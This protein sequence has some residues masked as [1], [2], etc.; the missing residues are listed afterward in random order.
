VM[1][2]TNETTQPTPE[3]PAT[4]PRAVIPPASSPTSPSEA[5]LLPGTVVLPSDPARLA[6]TTRTAVQQFHAAAAP[7]PPPAPSPAT[8]AVTPRLSSQG[9][10]HAALVAETRA[11]VTQFHASTTSPAPTGEAEK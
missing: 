8:P 11:I 10:D 2:T 7:T 6:E 9:P 4:T 5:G 1:K 3:R